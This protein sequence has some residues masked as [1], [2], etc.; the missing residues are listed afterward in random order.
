MFLPL[1]NFSVKSLTDKATHVTLNYSPKKKRP[2]CYPPPGIFRQI[3]AEHLGIESDHHF[4]RQI[5]AEHLGIESDFHFF[6][7]SFQ[8][9]LGLSQ[10]FI[11]SSNRCRTLGDWVRKCHLKNIPCNRHTVWKWG[12]CFHYFSSSLY[13]FDDL[14]ESKLCILK[15][16]LAKFGLFWRRHIHLGCNR[17]FVIEIG[18][19]Q[20][21]IELISNG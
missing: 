13:S 21:Q 12:L 5:V 18:D 3:V 8:N 7:K 9:T 6:V 17:N 4:F 11:F 15:S 14:P 1:D 20:V 16:I 2:D 10:T 19:V